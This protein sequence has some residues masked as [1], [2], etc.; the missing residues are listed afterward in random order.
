[1]IHRSANIVGHPNI[2]IGSNTR[3]DAFTS[4]TATS[5]P[6]SIGSYVHISCYVFVAGRAGFDL[7]D[8]VGVAAGARLF[9]TSD[10]FGGDVLVGP[11]VP[12]ELTNVHAQR[13]HLGRH[14]LAGVNS[15]VLP[16]AVLDEGTVLGALSLASK[17]LAAWTI[18]G[19]VPAIPL[20]DRRRNLLDLE[21][22]LTDG[23]QAQEGQ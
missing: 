16:G 1:M 20:K 8:F 6:C 12:T 23:A 3:I 10:D 5:E 14:S 17:P 11:T 21:R 7:G 15:V 2:S 9:S 22:R 4:I 19:G 13:L 18:Y